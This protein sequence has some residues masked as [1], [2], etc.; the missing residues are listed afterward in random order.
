MDNYSDNNLVI[1]GGGGHA[2][3]IIDILRQQGIFKIVGVV[4]QKK[5]VGQYHSDIPIIGDDSQLE[6][7]FRQG[8][9]NA[10]VAIGDNSLRARL[11]NNLKAIGFNLINMI[12]SSA[13]I[14]PSVRISAGSVIMPGAVLNTNC[15]IQENVIINTKASLDHDCV[16]MNHCHIAPGCTL[17]GRVSIGEGT[18]IGAGATVI[19]DVSIGAWSIIGAGSV[20]VSDIP[21]HVVA[22]GIPARI[23]R[24]LD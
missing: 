7:L 16:V 14:S 8:L 10:A 9:H 23:I 17:T 12:H 11:Y 13:V 24:N 5:R 22:Y 3:V 1:I 21:N 2:N 19:P 20:V 6:S 15:L 4:E 18:F